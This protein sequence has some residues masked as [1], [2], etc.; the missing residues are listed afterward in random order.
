MGVT[1]DL[2]EWTVPHGVCAPLISRWP[3]TGLEGK[4]SMAYV[5]AAADVATLVEWLVPPEA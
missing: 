3:Q 5:V 4:F 2:A 1:R